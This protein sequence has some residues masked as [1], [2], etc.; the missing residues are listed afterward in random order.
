MKALAEKKPESKNMKPSVRSF[1]DGSV[2]PF[3][4]DEIQVCSQ[5]G[6][7]YG[8]REIKGGA[9]RLS[10]SNTN[11]KIGN[12]GKKHFEILSAQEDIIT[13]TVLMVMAF[14]TERTPN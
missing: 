13:F 11:P 2:Q 5:K 12:R 9:C 10:T 3:L 14:G 1:S 7:D 4:L 6:R 8:E